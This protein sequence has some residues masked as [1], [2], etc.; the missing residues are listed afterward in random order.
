MRAGIRASNEIAIGPF[1]T[2][3]VDK[4]RRPCVGIAATVLLTLGGCAQMELAQAPEPVM[5]IGGE[6]YVVKQMTAGTWTATTQSPGGAATA[7]K[8]DMLKAIEAS[9]GCKVSDSTYAL[10]GTQL[11]AQ[12]NCPGPKD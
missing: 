4:H 6:G 10:G 3:A 12:V 2:A 8:T 9:S 1:E 7:S 11:N 5:K